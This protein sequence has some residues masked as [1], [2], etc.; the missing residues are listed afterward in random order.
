[1]KGNLGYVMNSL[2]MTLVASATV[3]LVYE[4]FMRMDIEHVLSE[5]LAPGFA[6]GLSSKK[7]SEIDFLFLVKNAEDFLQI[8]GLSANDILS[9]VP[10]NAI[11]GRLLNEKLFSVH[12]LLINPYSTEALLRSTSPAYSKPFMFFEK[13]KH[14][15]SEISDLGSELRKKG[16][17][18]KH[19][20]ARVYST[21]ATLSMIIDSSKALVTPLAYHETGGRSHLFE[22]SAASGSDSLYQHF[23]KHF[24]TV[25]HSA[26][27]IIGTDLSMLE[28]EASKFEEKLSTMRY[29]ESR[30]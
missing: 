21:P 27:P 5:R 10:L 1:M 30:K 9:P 11:R 17:D 25:W 8:I 6:F 18:H 23:M 2:G 20:D 13:T 29:D 14:I 19:F 15:I 26:T 28:L 12:I 22:V 16:I 4:V 7:R 24:E 3:S